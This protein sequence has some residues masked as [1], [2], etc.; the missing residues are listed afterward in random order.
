VKK[1]VSAL[2]QLEIKVDEMSA[3]DL[4]KRIRGPLLSDLDRMRTQ[5]QGLLSSMNS[6]S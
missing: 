4:I 3:A 2:D 5:M 6:S 1:L